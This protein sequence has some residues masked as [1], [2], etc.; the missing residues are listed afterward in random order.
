M[1]SSNEHK[2]YLLY[3]L[4]LR[5]KYKR[6]R[7]AKFWSDPIIKVRYLEETY[8][9]LFEKLKNGPRKFFNY[10]RMSQDTFYYMLGNLEQKIKKQDTSFRMAIPPEEMLV[11]TPQRLLVT[12]VKIVKSSIR[13]HFHHRT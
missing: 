13:I 9:T 7:V 2:I 11:V 1:A 5:R 3:L 8:Y 6:V 12:C 4:H 10:F